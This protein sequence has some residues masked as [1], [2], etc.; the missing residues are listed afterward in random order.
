[1]KTTVIAIEQKDID[2]AREL[3][4]KNRFFP[5]SSRLIFKELLEFYIQNKGE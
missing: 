4:M 3:F 5:K 2:K 1:M